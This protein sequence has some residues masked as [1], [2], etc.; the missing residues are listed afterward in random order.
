MSCSV[1]IPYQV[2][3]YQ[4]LDGLQGILGGGQVVIPYQVRSYQT[5]K[6]GGKWDADSRCRNPLSGQVISNR[7][8]REGICQLSRSVVIP[9][10]VRS[11]QTAEAQGL[12]VGEYLGV[13][14]PY[15]VR[16]YQTKEKAEFRQNNIDC[17]NPLSSQVI[18]N[19]KKLWP[20][21]MHVWS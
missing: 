18:S 2:R 8:T 13:V 19:Q 7:L 4:T 20:N 15:Q 21:A 10:Q 11:Y 12:T 5:K 14:I 16:S 3:S 17:R 6:L 9:Y 1:V